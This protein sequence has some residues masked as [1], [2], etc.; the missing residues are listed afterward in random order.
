MNMGVAAGTRLSRYQIIS[1]LGKGGMGE[2]Y[3]AHDTQL[4]RATALKILPESLASDN[5]RMQRFAQEARTTSGLNHPNILTIYEIGKVDGINFIACELVDGITLRQLIKDPGLSLPLKLDVAVQIC[6]ALSVAHAAGVIHR[7]IKPENV[8]V[9]TDGFVKILDFGLA[10][11]TEPT[12]PSIPSDPEAATKPQINTEPRV[13]MGTVSYMSPEQARGLELDARTDIWSSGAVLYETV[14]GQMAFKGSTSSDIVASILERDPAP[15]SL[16]VPEVPVELERIVSKSLAKDREERYQTIKDLLI[17][18]RSLKRNL[19]ANVERERAWKSDTDTGVPL[20][21][22]PVVTEDR[23]VPGLSRGE[24]WMSRLKQHKLL[25]SLLII[26]IV[27]LCLVV[28]FSQNSSSI[29]S[30]AVLPFVTTGDSDME[31]IG[32]G[33]SESIINSFTQL[34]QL[35]VLPQSMVSR[36]KGQ[37]VDSVKVGKELGVGAV[38]TGRIFRKN[39]AL[40]IKVDLVDVINQKQLLVKSYSRTS[41]DALGG[42]AISAMQEEISKQVFEDLRSKLADKR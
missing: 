33:I 20:G 24:H 36:Y 31:Y 39:D 9:R 5:E 15:L 23:A 17:D 7:D 8:M 32:S 4:D 35:R 29:N 30:L 3:L 10:K 14:T 40:I 13:V 26:L 28:Y 12:R 38:L 1:F 25:A 27:A 42:A 18:L 2:V 21:P 6:S 41:S 19:E 11:L 34:P 37:E 22:R 16:G